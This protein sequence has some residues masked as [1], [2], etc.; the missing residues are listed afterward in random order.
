MRAITVSV[1]LAFYGVVAI[2][3]TKMFITKTDGGV[4]SVSLS[5]IKTIT[6][7]TTASQ[8]GITGNWDMMASYPGKATITGVLALTDANGVVAG[9]LVLSRVTAMS[10][11]A[12]LS[13]SVTLTGK[14]PISGQWHDITATLNLTG[15]QMNG[16]YTPD[17]PWGLPYSLIATKR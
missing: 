9:Q 8:R 3:Q 14:E 4:D 16:T 12:T 11:S 7:K 5:Q 6:F 2:S 15:N 1:V 10:G 17:S 13:G